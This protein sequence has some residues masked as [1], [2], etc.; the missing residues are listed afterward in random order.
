[1]AEADLGEEGPEAGLDAFLGAVV[2]DQFQ[3]HP[4]TARANGDH[5]GDGLVAAVGEDAHRQRIA[6]LR[7][8]QVSAP[9]LDEIG[10]PDRRL[11][12]E[13]ARSVVDCE[14]FSLE[15]RRRAFRD[16]T[17]LLDEESP[18]DV[19]GY[20]LR[21]YAPL[22]E[23]LIALCRQ[24]EQAREWTEEAIRPLEPQLADPLIELALE[25]AE[26]QLTFLRDDV[27]PLEAG[28]DDP[29]LRRRL[30]RAVAAGQGAIRR[31]TQE[32]RRR[33]QPEFQDVALGAHGLEAMLL[34][35][36]GLARSVADL[37]EAADAELEALGEERAEVLTQSFAG[38]GID[39]VRRELERDHF[40]QETLISGAD[41]LL[42]ELRDFVEAN[43]EVPIPDGPPCVVRPT[44]GFLSAWVSA[45]Y[46]GAGPLERL[47]LPCLYY[48][49]TPQSGW[50]AGEADEWLRYL[51]RPTLKNTTVHEVFPGHHVQYLYS[52][53]I[54]TDIRRFFWSS[55]FGE[56]WAH[57]AE[58]LMVERGLA[59]GDPALRLAQIED[60]LVRACRFR[61]TLGIHAEGWPVEEGTRL[62]IDRIGIE[63]LP[64]RREAMRATFDPL[65]LVYTLGKRE[66]LGWREEWL[67]SGRGDLRAFHQRLLS[68]GS[69]PLAALGRWLHSAT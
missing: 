31:I 60:A 43:A 35:Q 49:T 51:N 26:G 52:L 7:R 21:E 46:E 58:L 59:E 14:L 41:G 62:F 63:E 32:L 53:S 37:R 3:A 24:L 22:P 5:S 1:M 48:V 6:T 45:A 56:G 38:Q 34:T 64:A 20:L 12:L 4:A 66:I 10:E 2:R 15:V 61:T 8:L 40:S 17:S 11:D 68:A 39:E 36:E 55:G 42:G 65:Y 50:S 67:R 30:E 44:P 13:A 33:R 28:V 29:Q 9:S 18:L 25:G 23:R 54:R 47:P 57:Y 16:P 19:G 27:A 69:P